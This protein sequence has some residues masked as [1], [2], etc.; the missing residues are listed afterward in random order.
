MGY[1]FSSLG[2]I[3]NIPSWLSV[4]CFAALILLFVIINA[5]AFGEH[6]SKDGR[7]FLVLTCVCF[8]N[9]IMN[10]LATITWDGST[11]DETLL[12]VANFINYTMTTSLF[13]IYAFYV[14]VKIEN[15]KF[16]AKCLIFCLVLVFLVDA[17]LCLSSIWD[18]YYFYYDA[19]SY[20]RGHFFYIHVIL[21]VIMASLVEAVI[22]SSAKQL[23]RHTLKYYAFF[24]VLPFLGMFFQIIFYGLPMGLIF[25]TFAILFVSFYRKTRSTEV[26]Y[27]TGIANRKKLD[28]ELY[29]RIKDARPGK[30]FSLI[31]VDLDGFK[32]INDNLGH[33][34]GDL[35]LE[36]AALVL[37]KSLPTKNDFVG[38]YGGDEFCLVISTTDES[39]LEKII[40]NIK[41]NLDN[42]NSE[43]KR[44]YKL[45][46]SM[47]YEQ[48][49]PNSKMQ[50]H[51]F[52]NLVDSEMYVDKAK[53]DMIR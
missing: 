6:E 2:N 1:L 27:L 50:L 32:S 28:S 44:P 35:A 22:F 9:L 14:Y 17:G 52:Y 53:K 34:V 26:D 47:G 37:K 29:E 7:L 11:T 48:Y 43:T 13:V 39:E 15:D 18:G 23:D 12:K 31:L 5:F 8:V 19:N 42:Y 51:D 33:T 4:S 20:N 30:S 45:G 16:P 49:D 36:D 38:R 10:C 24:P 40:A 41:V 25:V 46:F 21:L 3:I